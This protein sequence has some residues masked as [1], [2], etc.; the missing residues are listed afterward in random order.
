MRSANASSKRSSTVST[1]SRCEPS[2]ATTGVLQAPMEAAQSVSSLPQSLMG[3]MGGAA[4]GLGAGAGAAG[5]AGVGAF[6]GA[7]LTSYTRP[8]STFEPETGG[9]PTGLRTGVSNVAEIHSPT[10]PAGQ[11]DEVRERWRA[12]GVQVATVLV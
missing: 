7:G 11:P 4:G 9:L 2:G 6:P 10:T 3:S 8:A 12:V 5:G 1:T